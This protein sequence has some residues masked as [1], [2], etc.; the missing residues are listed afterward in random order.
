MK[1]NPSAKNEARGAQK[2]SGVWI[3]HWFSIIENH[4]HIRIQINR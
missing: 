4:K 3:N 2:L 1:T